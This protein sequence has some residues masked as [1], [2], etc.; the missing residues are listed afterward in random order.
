MCGLAGIWGRRDDVVVAEMNH[1]QRHRGPDGVGIWG[2][3]HGTL[4]HRRLAIVDPQGGE[5]PI[6][7]EDGSRTLIANGE[8]YNHRLLRSSLENHHFS[9]DSDSESILHLF[10]EHGGEAVRKLDGMFAFAIADEGRL[11]L[12]RDPLGIKP[13][14]YV[15]DGRGMAF[16][17][18]LKA[19]V[20]VSKDVR[21]FPPGAYFCSRKGFVRYYDLPP[22]TDAGMTIPETV[23]RLRETLEVSVQKRLL[24]DVPVGAFLSGGLDSS[25][26]VALARRHQPVFHTVCVGTAGSSDLAA[27]REV[28]AQLGTRHHEHVL[29]PDDVARHLPEIIYHLESFD[30]DLVRSAIPNYFASLVAREHFK[31]VLTGEGSDE[32]FAGY[33]YHEGHHL[34]GR[35]NHELRESVAALHNLNLQRC[36]RMTMAHGVEGRVPF[37]DLKMIELAFAI[38]ASLKIVRGCKKWILRAAATG[39]LDDRIVWRTK[40]QFDQGSGANAILG[41]VVPKMIRNFGIRTPTSSSQRELEAALYRELFRREFPREVERLVAGWRG[42]AA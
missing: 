40:T 20:R 13:L 7:N 25:L 6:Q 8:I 23:Q 37:L 24:S 11:F 42:A 2:D 21:E 31:V 9:T 17:S 16:A 33:T 36:D 12:A 1:L 14:Y 26:V 22:Q 35:L 38:P 41:E 34:R 29:T 30:V 10:E 3:A 32:L 4:G 39:V 19:I 5:Q 28:A 27:A 18:E 15:E